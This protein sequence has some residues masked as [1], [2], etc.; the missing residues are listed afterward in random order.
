MGGIRF[1][2]G[3]SEGFLRHHGDAMLFCISLP[4]RASG[5]ECDEG[6]GAAVWLAGGLL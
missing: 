5:L 2:R 3:N 1:G 4:A 6:N